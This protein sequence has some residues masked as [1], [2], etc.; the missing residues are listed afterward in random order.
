[1]LKIHFFDRPSSTQKEY[2]VK[3]RFVYYLRLE[4]QV[5]ERF[6]RENGGELVVAT[7]CLLEVT[8]SS[9]RFFMLIHLQTIMKNYS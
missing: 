9:I 4:M 1:M 7:L 2:V 5:M 6:E 8:V 3:R